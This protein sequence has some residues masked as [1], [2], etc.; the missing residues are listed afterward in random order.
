MPGKDEGTGGKVSAKEEGQEA[1]CQ[2]GR[3][4]Q[5]SCHRRQ[6]VKQGGWD[7]RHLLEGILAAKKV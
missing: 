1:R 2:A 7:K 3:R 6:G 5:D 4:G